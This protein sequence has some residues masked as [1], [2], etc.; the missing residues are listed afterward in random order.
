[1]FTDKTILD[2]R[3][4]IN[5]AYSNKCARAALGSLV[6]RNVKVF[7]SMTSNQRHTWLAEVGLPA[8]YYTEV[9][10]E[11]GTWQYDN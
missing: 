4:E 5:T 9:M 1:M 8:S 6:R 7:I 11:I 2:Q 10:K 3:S